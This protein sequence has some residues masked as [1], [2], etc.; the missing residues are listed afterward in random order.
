MLRL[1][2]VTY[3][4]VILFLLPILLTL[5]WSVYTIAKTVARDMPHTLGAVNA[6]KSKT[7]LFDT[8]RLLGKS[9]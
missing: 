8:S 2:A 7:R 9:D 6:T 1:G 3:Y 5:I 4:A